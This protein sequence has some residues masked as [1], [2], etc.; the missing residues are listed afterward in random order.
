ENHNVRQILE[1]TLN[2]SEIRSLLLKAPAAKS[3][4]HARQGGLLEHILSICGILDFMAGHYKVVDRSLLIFGAIYHDLGKIWELQYD[5]GVNYTT[6][7][8]LIGHL[9]MAVE[10]VEK[11]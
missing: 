6:E 3:I 2:D 8:R 1:N 9:M 5:R 7:G 4:H 11:K 10:L